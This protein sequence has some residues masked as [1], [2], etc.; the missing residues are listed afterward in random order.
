[1][2]LGIY[3]ETLSVHPAESVVYD[4]LEIREC[5][6]EVLITRHS[7]TP[8]FQEGI[9]QGTSYQGERA[10]RTTSTP[11]LPRGYAEDLASMSGSRVDERH[12][13]HESPTMKLERFGG[14]RP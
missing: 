6:S 3:V 11:A 12:E 14:R 9:P 5:K 10:W 13:K 8:E 7:V 2:A 1:M 4:R